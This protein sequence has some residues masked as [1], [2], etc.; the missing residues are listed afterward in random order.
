ML[1]YATLENS[2]KGPFLPALP[3]LFRLRFILVLTE[4]GDVVILKATPERHQEVASFSAIEGKT[5]NHPAIAGGILLVRN[6]R[7]MAAY[8]LGR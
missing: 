6:A 1:F 2:P 8:R 4:S 7:E 3:R 5:W